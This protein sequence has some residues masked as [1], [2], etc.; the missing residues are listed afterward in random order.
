MS[1]TL[2]SATGRFLDGGSPLPV[3]RGLISKPRKK[4]KSDKATGYQVCSKLQTDVRSGLK[5]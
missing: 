3:C 4:Q 1:M 2:L 5:A